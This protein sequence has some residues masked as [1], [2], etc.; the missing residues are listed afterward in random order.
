[1]RKEL[2]GRA[3]SQSN[4]PSSPQPLSLRIHRLQKEQIDFLVSLSESLCTEDP[5]REPDRTGGRN[6]T[7]NRVEPSQ[8]QLLDLMII[9]VHGNTETRD[10]ELRCI[11]AFKKGTGRGHQTAGSGSKCFSSSSSM[12]IQEL[13]GSH[14]VLFNE[15]FSCLY[16]RITNCQQFS[17]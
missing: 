17:Y 4:P 7:F 8:K 6:Q 10:L 16:S 9:D 3:H 2:L 15:I 1:M 13:S 5:Q 12:N 14:L 11:S